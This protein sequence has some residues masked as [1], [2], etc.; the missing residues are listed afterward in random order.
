MRRLVLVFLFSSS[1]V[2]AQTNDPSEELNQKYAKHM[3]RLK[4]PLRGEML[5]FDAAGHSDGKPGVFGLDDAINIEHIHLKERSLSIEGTRAL[6]IFRPDEGVAKYGIT[7]TVR[8][9]IA[10]AA[11][12]SPIEAAE[13]SMAKVFLGGREH[14]CTPEES[15]AFASAF[16]V[17]IQQVG[18]SEEPPVL[19]CLPTGTHGYWGGKGITPPEVVRK[20]PP[21]LSSYKFQRSKRDQWNGKITFLLLVDVN[22]VPRDVI[23]LAGPNIKALYE[24]I[25]FAIRDWRYRPAMKDGEAVS[26]FSVI[27]IN[28]AVDSR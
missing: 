6:L 9:T 12:A 11:G 5:A 20:T 10:L 23:T 7:T 28:V 1:I 22:G 21:A 19:F 24:D 27:T 3:V 13:A 25:G 8:L 18:L 14:S 15:A 17:R 16:P 26:M 2:F 4:T